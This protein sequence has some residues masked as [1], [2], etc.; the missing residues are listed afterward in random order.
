MSRKT[1]ELKRKSMKSS[2]G[3][4]EKP[5]G[6]SEKGSTDE[7]NSIHNR[8]WSRVSNIVAID[9]VVLI[10]VAGSTLGVDEKLSSTLRFSSRIDCTFDVGL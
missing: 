8:N 4:T 5:H 9:V 6:K 2:R 3:P 10:A 1:Q 7:E